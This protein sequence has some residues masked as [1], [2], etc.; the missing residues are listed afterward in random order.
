MQFNT[1]EKNQEKKKKEK[2]EGGKH[3]INGEAV[4]GLSRT[5]DFIGLVADDIFFNTF[6][7]PLLQL[8]RNEHFSD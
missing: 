1:R 5:G 7:P 4:C 3:L 6:A 8:A 2:K